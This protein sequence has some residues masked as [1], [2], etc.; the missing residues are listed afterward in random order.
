MVLERAYNAG[1]AYVVFGSNSGFG[2]TDGT[3]RQVLDLTTLI[4]G[5]GLHHP[6]RRGR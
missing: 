6:G 2:T 5:R 4:L 1:E 3:G